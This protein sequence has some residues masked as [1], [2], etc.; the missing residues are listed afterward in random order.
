MTSTLQ[1]G[2]PGKFGPGRFNL[3]IQL[4]GD[5]DGSL[6]RR[7]IDEAKMGPELVSSWNEL[8]DFDSSRSG[9]VSTRNVTFD[10]SSRKNFSQLL[11]TTP[12]PN[13]HSIKI[14]KFEEGKLPYSPRLRNSFHFGSQ[15][16]REAT[17]GYKG[18]SFALTSRSHLTRSRKNS[19]E[20][21]WKTRQTSVGSENVDED[22]RDGR[23]TAMSNTESQG[24]ITAESSIDFMELRGPQAKR[25]LTE[26]NLN[27]T[28]GDREDSFLKKI[29]ERNEKRQCLRNSME[30]ITFS[31]LDQLDTYDKSPR[32]HEGSFSKRNFASPRVV[33]VPHH[34]K[35]PMTN[36]DT[37]VGQIGLISSPLPPAKRGVKVGSK[38]SRVKVEKKA[39]LDFNHETP[40]ISLQA[41][42]SPQSVREF[43][44]PGQDNGS[45][46]R[47]RNQQENQL[48]HFDQKKIVERMLSPTSS[49][50][51]S[52]SHRGSISR[53][54][55]N[56]LLDNPKKTSSLRTSKLAGTK[57]KRRS[58]LSL[59]TNVVNAQSQMRMIP[60]TSPR[61]ESFINRLRRESTMTR[62]MTMTESSLTSAAVRDSSPNISTSG[63]FHVN[64]D[65]SY[66]L[67]KGQDCD[68]FSNQVQVAEGKVNGSQ[69]PIR[70]LHDAKAL[71]VSKSCQMF[72]KGMKLTNTAIDPQGAKQGFSKQS[73]VRS[74][75]CL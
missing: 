66:H 54:N 1:G 50:N 19:S 5:F 65:L 43:R 67:N 26:P 17:S 2:D 11:S 71:N 44:T 31:K 41:I 68:Y 40:K 56:L 62:S 53:V 42:L 57:S 37:S 6:E 25:V 35:K 7:V 18:S 46:G 69:S 9:T 64:V 45:A 20:V 23:I 61:E 74:G 22:G 21:G 32:E 16:H 58:P 52:R 4:P 55:L 47:S 33:K 28:H 3:E 48:S 49:N 13:I 75:N 14:N 38:K 39:P 27:A 60:L 12:L 72:T 34:G 24:G 51:G 8:P 29:K 73:P 36:V 70:V 30:G 10:I 63:S 15:T 59:S